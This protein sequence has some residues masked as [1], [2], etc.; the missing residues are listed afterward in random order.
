M[1][2]QKIVQV[3]D[4]V[5]QKPTNVIVKRDLSVNFVKFMKQ[6]VNLIVVDILL[7]VDA[8]KLMVNVN[9][10]QIT[11]EIIVNLAFLIVMIKI[12]FVQAKIKEPAFHLVFANA[13]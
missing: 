1:I 13:N 12:N 11:M 3:M 2:V 10:T 8:M 9:A 7:V 5:I 4:H 6:N